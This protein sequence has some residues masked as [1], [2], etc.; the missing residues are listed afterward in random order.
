MR[1]TPITRLTIIRVKNQESD[2]DIACFEVEVNNKILTQFD[3]PT[4][5]NF[6]HVLGFARKAIANYWLDPEL[7]RLEKELGISND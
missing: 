5:G 1:N 7:R 3:C 4:T 2:N 6:T